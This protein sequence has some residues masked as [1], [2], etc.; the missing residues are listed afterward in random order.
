[1]TKPKCIIEEHLLKQW[2]AEGKTLTQMSRLSGYSRETVQRNL[3]DYGLVAPTFRA[4]CKKFNHVQLME[5][6]RLY[7]EEGLSGSQIGLRYGVDQSLITRAIRRL[8]FPRRS[9]GHYRVYRLNENFFDTID[10]E[11][12]AYWLGFLYADGGL[13][14]YEA[15]RIKTYSIRLGLAE[16]DLEILE[17]LRDTLYPDKDKPIAAPKHKGGYT[18]SSQQRYLEIHSKHMFTSLVSKGCGL[19]KSLMLQFPT[20]DQVPDALIRHF[21]R[22][23]F[24]GDGCITW[25]TKISRIAASFG[26][27]SSKD[28]VEG[29]ERILASIGAPGHLRQHCKSPVWYVHV[30]RQISLK[31]IYHYLYDD[32]TVF[33]KRKRVKYDLLM[34]RL[35]ER[36]KVRGLI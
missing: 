31:R 10:T 25:N 33:L 20:S 22:G 4:E 5:I 2:I 18:G 35:D 17:R 21:I 8:G 28:F 36:L 12:K 27:V 11:E 7:Q 23:Y 13:V 30:G 26:M 19:R 3:R 9:V 14:H 15:P 34:G 32:A 29:A 16:V 1:M 6:V 24:D